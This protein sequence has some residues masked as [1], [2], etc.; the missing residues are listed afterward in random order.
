MVSQLVADP[1]GPL[2]RAGATSLRSARLALDHA[3]EP[4]FAVTTP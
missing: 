2:S 1:S 3:D 4:A